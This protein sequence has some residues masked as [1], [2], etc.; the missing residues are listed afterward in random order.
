MIYT[1][2]KVFVCVFV[3]LRCE[4]TSK[5]TTLKPCQEGA[6]ASWIQTS[7]MEIKMSCS[8]TLVP[9]CPPSP[10]PRWIRS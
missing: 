8:K 2:V 6:S 7:S 3:G 4:Q 9:V 5:L 10:R 1:P